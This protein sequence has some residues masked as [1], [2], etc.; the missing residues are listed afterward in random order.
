MLKALDLFCGAGGAPG[1]D[2]KKLDDMD[3]RLRTVEGAVGSTS[4]KKPLLVPATAKIDEPIET[5]P[6]P[7]PFIPAPPVVPAYHAE[8]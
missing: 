3:K 8:A 1:A 2:A 5:K 4:F 7:K 6:D